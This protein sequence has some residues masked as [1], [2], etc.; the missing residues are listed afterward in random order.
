M[1]PIR[2]LPLLLLVALPAR[3]LDDAAAAQVIEAS[4]QQL[5]ATAAA[6]DPAQSPSFTRADGSWNTVASTDSLNWTQGFFPGASWYLYDLTGDAAARANAEA[7]TRALEGQKT[8]TQTHDLGFKML[9]S[10][11]HA[12]RSTGDPY[13]RDVL[14]TA[15]GSLAA[16]YDPALGV[17]VCCDWNPDWHRPVVIDTMMNL[18]LLLWGARNGGPASWQAMALSHALKSLQDLVRPDGSTFHVVDYSSSGAILFRG[19]SQGYADASTW[20]RGQAWAIYGYTAVYRYTSDPRML[21]AAQAT[22]DSYLAR[23]G[24]DPIPN[25]DFDAPS[26]QKDSSAAAVVASALFELA[27]YVGANDRQRYLEAASAMLDA[28]ASPA[29][30]DAGASTQALLLHGTAN[31]PAGEQIDVGLSYGDHYFLEALA[32]RPPQAAPGGGSASPGVELCS[33][34][35]KCPPASLRQTPTTTSPTR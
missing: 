4:R 13:Y 18:E 8:N 11:G 34:A 33:A 12:F 2:I 24:P 28:L 30:F 17:I 14:L 27:G 31:Y 29:Y 7:W 16:R 19:T 25:W 5:A 32:R 15:A 21:A 23:L 9:L 20:T 3:A 6:L 10:F 35:W 1:P 26:V 22:A